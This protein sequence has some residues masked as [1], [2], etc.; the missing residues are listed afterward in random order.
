MSKEEEAIKYFEEKVKDVVPEYTETLIDGE[1]YRNEIIPLEFRFSKKE[2]EKMQVILNLMQSQQKELEKLKNKNKDLLRK[3]RNRVKEVKK[4]AKYS[5]Y[6]TEFS[7]LNKE[8]EKYK[9][10]YEKALTDL[11]KTEGNNVK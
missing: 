2:A 6:K 3:L 10:L 5:L 11:V 4:L 8:I 7:R 9:Y 1:I